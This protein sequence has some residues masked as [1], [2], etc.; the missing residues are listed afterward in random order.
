M[1]PIPLKLIIIFIAIALSTGNCQEPFPEDA[2]PGISILKNSNINEMEFSGI[3][4]QRE[5]QQFFIVSDNGYL[6]AV[7]P[8]YSTINQWYIG[9]DLEGVTVVPG[10]PD[11]VYL[12]NENPDSILE[13][14][15]IS[16]QTVRSFDLT[17]WLTGPANSGL[18]ALTFVTDANSLESGFFYAGLQD[19]GC[20]YVF[21]LPIISS[22]SSTYVNYIR[23]IETDA[24][25]ISGLDYNI[26]Q[27]QLY[28]IH[29]KHDLLQAINLDGTIAD[30]WQLPGSSQE[31]IALKGT[32]L[33][34]TE[35]YGSSNG[36]IIRYQPVTFYNQPDINCD[37]YVTLP[38][39]AFLAE[40]WLKDSKAM[41]Y[42][43]ISKLELFSRSWLK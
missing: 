18:E 28:A 23:L 7:D 20:I 6:E 1:P 17:D 37:G 11:F 14:N 13:F 9:I 5:L 21:E 8:N 15:I 40:C 38:D 2:L 19:N 26:S 3:V 22:T 33:Y 24:D 4:W 36:D 32:E 39:F 35:D 30:E 12:G 42:T 10:R 31:G 43:D 27:Q 41:G 29:D 34:I 25:D 16:G